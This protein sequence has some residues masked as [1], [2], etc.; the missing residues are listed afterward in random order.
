MKERGEKEELLLLLQQRLLHQEKEEEEWKVRANKTKEG[1]ERKWAN[2]E[3]RLYLDQ[4]HQS[5][6]NSPLIHLKVRDSFTAIAETA[7][8]SA[9]MHPKRKKKR[10][11]Q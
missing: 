1:K 5:S 6:H 11:E 7:A 4:D 2:R 3:N 8:A 9:A 10:I